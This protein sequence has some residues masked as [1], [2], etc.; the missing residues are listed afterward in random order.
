M[1]NHSTA[2][3][4]SLKLSLPFSSMN[5]ILKL[6][7]QPHDCK[8]TIFKYR[9]GNGRPP[10]VWRKINVSEELSL[11]NP[12]E[13]ENYNQSIYF[14]TIYWTRIQFITYLSNN[15]I[16]VFAVI[17]PKTLNFFRFHIWVSSYLPNV[18][19]FTIANFS[20][21]SVL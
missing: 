3:L 11:F 13:N 9:Q 15:S 4:T 19:D 8:G 21:A 16:C 7:V 6:Y 17:P 20:S 12:L 10:R 14:S 18:I 1:S 5:Q 2:F